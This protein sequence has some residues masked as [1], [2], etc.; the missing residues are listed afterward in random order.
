MLDSLSKIEANSIAEELIA[1]RDKVLRLLINLNFTLFCQKPLIQRFYRL[2]QNNPQLDGNQILLAVP[3]EIRRFIMDQLAEIEASDI[4]SS[5]PSASSFPA[6]SESNDSVALKILEGLKKRDKLV[7][8]VSSE[9][10]KR[11]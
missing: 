11:K 7:P 3:P 5:S 9:G 8:A 1:A 6:A 2:M 4:G 10:T